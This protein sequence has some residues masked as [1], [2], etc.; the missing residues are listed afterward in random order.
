M[1]ERWRCLKTRHFLVVLVS[2]A[3]FGVQKE[4]RT[5]GRS[6]NGESPSRGHST[7]YFLGLGD[8]VCLSARVSS[9]ASNSRVRVRWTV[10]G[11]R[12]PCNET[13]PISRGL[14]VLPIQIHEPFVTVHNE[15]QSNGKI[16]SGPTLN[17]RAVSSLVRLFYVPEPQLN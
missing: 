1:Q 15:A 9:G 13:H 7:F 16:D 3:V 6:R 4:A 14:I 2:A 17:G 12:I 8:S 10:V 5:D 11:W